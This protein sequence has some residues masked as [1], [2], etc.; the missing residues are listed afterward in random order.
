[1]RRLLH[2]M[3]Y[4]YGFRR[5]DLPGR[6][7]LVFRSRRKMVFVHSCPGTATTAVKAGFLLAGS[8]TG[9]KKSAET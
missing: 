7:D 6:L 1:M 5:R 2:R 8:I 3:D 9:M 4:R